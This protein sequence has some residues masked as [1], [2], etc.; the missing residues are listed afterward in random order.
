MLVDG[1]ILVSVQGW[2]EGVARTETL[3]TMAKIHVF[4]G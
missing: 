2:L 4:P 3:D 1:V